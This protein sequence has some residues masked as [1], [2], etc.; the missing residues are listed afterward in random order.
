[1][2]ARFRFQQ[3]MQFLM[4]RLQASAI[5]WSSFSASSLNFSQVSQLVRSSP[6]ASCLGSS[7]H[8]RKPSRLA[9]TDVG[10]P[11]AFL[12]GREKCGLEISVDCRGGKG[13]HQLHA[14]GVDAVMVNEAEDQV[15]L[16]FST[17]VE[18]LWLEVR[19]RLPEPAAGNTAKMKHRAN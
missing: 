16:T 14:L 7:L 15:Y 8:G 2:P 19:K 12:T 6:V 1:M 5:S 18:R 4:S 13:H 10:T 17:R 3:M 9:P 11:C